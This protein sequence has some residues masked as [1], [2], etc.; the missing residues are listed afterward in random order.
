VGERERKKEEGGGPRRSW[1][2]GKLSP[3]FAGKVGRG[4]EEKKGKQKMGDVQ[5]SLGPEWTPISPFCRS[6]S[7]PR[8][9]KKR[10]GDKARRG[11][12]FLT[13]DLGLSLT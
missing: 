1:V 5:D 11:G 8:G 2:A 10:G 6:P 7:I 4:K 3:I 13:S 9:R 12:A